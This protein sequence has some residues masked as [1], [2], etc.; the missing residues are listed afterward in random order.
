MKSFLYIT[1][2]PIV[3]NLAPSSRAVMFQKYFESLEYNSRVIGFKGDDID[4]SI[5]FAKLPFSLSIVSIFLNRLFICLYIFFWALLKRKK[6]VIVFRDIYLSGTMALWCSICGVKCAYDFHA[7][8]SAEMRSNSKVGLGYWYTL[9]FEKLT[10]V[11]FNKAITVNEELGKQ[12]PESTSKLVVANGISPEEFEDLKSIELKDFGNYSRSCVFVGHHG[13]WSDLSV[14]NTAAVYF[15]ET[16]FFIVGDGYAVEEIKKTEVN[17]NVILTG[18]VKKEDA[19]S[20]VKKADIGLVCF[21]KKDE[22]QVGIDNTSNR[23]VKDYLYLGKPMIV[24]NVLPKDSLLI[25]GENSLF[26][27][28]DCAEDLKLK[29]DELLGNDQLKRTMSEKNREKSLIFTWD[30]IFK[31]SHLED[32]FL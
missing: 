11:L 17:S 12:L 10:K 4:G 30:K 14:I 13:T 21:T 24:S 5:Q 20:F 6:G 7:W 26:Y 16:C 9:F 1:A 27:E 15:P 8:L 2:Y 18:L 31:A 29:L 23:K 32:F 25:E 3:L 19:L 28:S 22:Y